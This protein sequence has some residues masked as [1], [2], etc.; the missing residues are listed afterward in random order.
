MERS[1]ERRLAMI[2]EISSSSWIL[3]SFDHA[4]PV[5][6]PRPIRISSRLA[7]VATLIAVCASLSSCSGGVGA[8]RP[9]IAL[10]T[11][12]SVEAGGGAFTATISGTGFASAV[13]LVNGQPVTV[14]LVNSTQLGVLIPASLIATPGTLPVVVMNTLPSGNIPSNSA[15]IIV[16]SGTGTAPSLTIS[17]SHS[18]NFSE[19]ETGATY[20]ITVTNISSAGTTNGQVDVTEVPPSTGL[21]VTN[22]AGN[23][24]SCTITN[25]TCSRT[26]ALGPGASYPTI[27]V[28][29]NVA[30][31]APATVTNEGAV[32]GG[33]SAPATASDPTTITTSSGTAQ[34]TAAIESSSMTFTQGGTGI[35][36]ITI[37]NSGSVSTTGDVT[38]TTQLDPNEILVSSNGGSF[39]N[40]T[41]GSTGSPVCTSTGN[42]AAGGTAQI[43]VTFALN[44]TFT[45]TVTFTLTANAPGANAVTAMI[46]NEVNP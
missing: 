12:S 37:G 36:T 2:S 17:K 27:T 33:G 15:A 5:R 44:A 10:I 23:G 26:D 30:T 16:T 19:G 32:S 39:F 25:L 9:V 40:C 38:V 31:N 3:G 35:Y 22:M 14:T 18:G 6:R 8:F 24:W 45:G 41:V 13:V 34:L 29:V 28:T 21:T 46:S 4:G 43:T 42:L 11:P 20:T 7:T 1:A